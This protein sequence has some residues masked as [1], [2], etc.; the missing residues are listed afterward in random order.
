LGGVVKTAKPVEHHKPTVPVTC[1]ARVRLNEK[2]LLVLT[3][4]NTK[5]ALGF[6]VLGLLMHTILV[7]MQ[8]FSVSAVE[9]ES[10]VRL[11][12]LGFMSWVVGG[13]GFAFITREGLVRLP[14]LITAVVPARLLRPV[15]AQ[16]EQVQIQS[17]VRVGITY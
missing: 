15:E 16:G 12:W 13:I 10:S 4:M 5:N 11:I 6:F 7:L 1:L 9:A 3:L 2:N 17:V 14:T 8:S